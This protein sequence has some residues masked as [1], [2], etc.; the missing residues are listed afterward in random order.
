M[1]AKT[2]LSLAA[3]VLG[4]AL[5]AIPAF[6]QDTYPTSRTPYDAGFM[7]GNYAAPPGD[8]YAPGGEPIGR[9]GYYNSAPGWGFNQNSAPAGDTYAPGGDQF[10]QSSY[11]NYSPMAGPLI[12][13]TGGRDVAYC[14]S[15]FHSY[16]P[17]TGTYRGFD[18]ARHPCP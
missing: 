10:R 13:G 5:T 9:S 2:A 11:Y 3:L 12:G 14:Q 4:T 1:R 8:T 16:D 18:G 6:A 7:Q 17:A 15:R